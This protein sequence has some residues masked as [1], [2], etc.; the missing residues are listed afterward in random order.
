MIKIKVTKDNNLFKKLEVNGHAMYDDIGKDIVCASVSSIV[1]TSVNGILSLN[2][3]S[4]SC[5][6]SNGSIKLDEIA[7]DNTT[8]TL[9]QNMV[10]LL[11]ELE[12]QY[13]TNIKVK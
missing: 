1:I 8:Q 2:E 10:N 9:I 5:E 7:N 6:S 11:T 3:G 13:P 4:L 12:E